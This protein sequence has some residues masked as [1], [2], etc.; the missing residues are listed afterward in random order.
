MYVV[1]DLFKQY[2]ALY[3]REWD[4]K[5]IIGAKTY[6]NNDV[7][8]FE[9]GDSITS[10]DDFSLGE[11]IS[12]TLVVSI[13]TSD[14][15]PSNAKLMPY[16]RLNGVSGYTEWLPLGEYYIDE[17]KFQNSVFKFS[18]FDR[19]IYGQMTYIP[20]ISFPATMLA[21]LDDVCLQLGITK[22]ASLLV[23]LSYM[24]SIA[25]IEYSLR[26]MLSGI[27][28]A[29]GSNAKL[30][31]D[32]KLLFIKVI[33]NPI[34]TQVN[35]S[36]Y[37]KAEQ[38][39]SL[40]SYSRLAAIYNSNG[41]MLVSGDLNAKI[42]NTLSFFCPFMTQII[43]DKIFTQISGFNYMPFTM[44]WR[45]LPNL[46]VGDVVE[47]TMRDGTIFSAPVMRNKMTFKGG[48]K[49]LSSASSLSTD[50]SEFTY[51]GSIKQLVQEMTKDIAQSILYFV[52]QNVL[53][54][55]TTSVPVA[56]IAIAATKSTN[57][58]LFFAIYGV[59]SVVN[60][61]TIGIQ[62]DNKN[63]IFIPKQKLNLG[64]NI[65]SIPLLIPQVAAGGHYL[66]VF[67]VV[68]TGTYTIPASNFQLV[69]EGGSLQGGLNSETPH[70]EVIQPVLFTSVKSG[71]NITQIVQ[72]ALQNPLAVNIVQ[73]VTKQATLPGTITQSMVVSMYDIFE[74]TN[75]N[76]VYAGTWAIASNVL[77]SANGTAMKTMEA[78]ATS[79]FNFTGTSLYVQG[80]TDN[81]GSSN[82]S[83]VIDGIAKSISQVSATSYRI[84]QGVSGLVDKEHYCTITNLTTGS[85]TIDAI[86]V[87]VGKILKAFNNLV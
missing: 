81:A 4:V 63:I 52:N 58:K 56:Y 44:D 40:K 78:N 37:M 54:I 83:V 79:K 42:N 30:G 32:G 74:E 12:S 24:I 47:I 45:G 75:A 23:D 82:I 25:P 22:D 6:L 36:D 7:I 43:L 5:I 76:I 48:L 27:A 70:A 84:M 65:I 72:A 69:I 31:K 13:H 80:Y 35:A 26:A 87:D 28:A 8:D 2:L 38:T 3:D 85:C 18:C 33:S 17:R 14:I 66:G 60:T 59:A 29:H 19:F 51:N 61:V 20:K 39:N 41:D 9:I 46:V 68:D 86:C 71:K 53:T 15:I 11:V 34:K 62:Y 77:Y 1:S 10:S 64:D 49:T 21:V 73:V 57:L 16:V 67:L 50:K 55:G